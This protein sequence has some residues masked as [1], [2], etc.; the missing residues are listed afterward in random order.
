MLVEQGLPVEDAVQLLRDQDPDGLYNIRNL[1]EKEL[2][3]VARLV[4]G[5]PR[6]LEV[7][8]GILIDNPEE[9]VDDLEK[10]FFQRE[11]VVN[12]V[13]EEGY[14]RLDDE[15]RRY[16]EALSVFRRTIPNVAV[17]FVLEPFFSG[18]NTP[19]IRRR[20]ARMNLIN[21]E[22]GSD[23]V[24]LHQ[25]DMDFAYSQL[26]EEGDYCRRAL[27]LRAAEFYEE[28][29]V[30]IN[31]WHTV[32]YVDAYIFQFD[33]L[34][35]A[36]A[37]DK[38][39]QVLGECSISLAW[40][41]YS[42]DALAM[43]QR[44]E[45]KIT[46]PQLLAI[47]ARGLANVYTVR[48][49]LPKAIKLFEKALEWA[50]G[51]GSDS[52]AGDVY[53]D[54]GVAYRY[55]GDLES[56]K[57][58]FRKSLAI[59]R[60]NPGEYDRSQILHQLARVCI[61]QG[62][63]KEGLKHASEA[64]DRDLTLKRTLFQG[65]DHS[66]IALAHLV[67]QNYDL[68]IKH[69]TQS[70]NMLSETRDSSQGWTLNTLGLA[71]LAQNDINKAQHYLDQ[72]YSQS[73]SNEQPRLQGFSLFNLAWCKRKQNEI[74]QAL[75][76]LE[77]TKDL[78]KELGAPEIDAVYAFIEAIEFSL[79]KNVQ[80]EIKCLLKCAKAIDHNPDLYPAGKVVSAA[81]EIADT[82]GLTDLAAEARR[83]LEQFNLRSSN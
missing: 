21:T 76:T 36:A 33:H 29:K 66:V 80:L 6:A 2:A 50:K 11:E 12:E 62:A 15:A 13:I 82:E 39:G 44:L 8:A 61:Y 67:A 51:S 27:E 65:I 17:D 42:S 32:H 14:K 40:R 30:P 10:Q 4:H 71:Y 20:L 9:S 48:G 35:K 26:P 77:E 5:V 16:M 7:A 37:Y 58:V 22:R 45:G 63:T 52:L 47:L 38:A 34:M 18:L 56:A 31:D 19:L 23:E 83:R 28:F 54:F 24:S 60:N 70:L 41:G 25:I 79:E 55:S 81:L 53:L 59:N 78:F 49:P 69:A 73:V 74:A 72:A 1:P 57:S 43:H 64:L 68:V 46:D 75:N 3:R